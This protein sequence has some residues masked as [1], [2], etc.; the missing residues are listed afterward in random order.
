MGI[1]YSV[2]TSDAAAVAMVRE[3]PMSFKD[4]VEVCRHVKGM[5]VRD[6]IEALERVI[7]GEEPVPMKQHNSDVGHRSDLEGWDAGRFPEK[8]TQGI[9]DA[10]ENAVAN[11]EHQG[12]DPDELT[13]DHLAAHK[14]GESEGMM[15]RAMGRATPANTPLV[16]VEVV[17]SP[18]ETTRE[19]DEDDEETETATETS[20]PEPEATEDE[21]DDD[22]D[23]PEA[24][25]EPE[26]AEDADDDGGADAD[27]E[28]DD[29][30]TADTEETDDEPEEAEA[31]EAAEADGDDEG[32]DA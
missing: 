24:D 6:A 27:D 29:E 8:A 7:D 3:R 17:L 14:V 12:H 22:E 23:E 1:S 15:S 13:V 18:P 9:V 10:L 5:P 11:A 19:P 2:D 25:D 16:D 31:A 20:E 4:S 28:T 21:A 30:A 32:G 26:E